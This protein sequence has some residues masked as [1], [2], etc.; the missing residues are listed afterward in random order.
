MDDE[1]RDGTLAEAADTALQAPSTV[2]AQCV[3]G[4]PLHAAPRALPG[5]NGRAVPY[6]ARTNA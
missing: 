6:R 4:T 3:C 2:R 5:G 1:K